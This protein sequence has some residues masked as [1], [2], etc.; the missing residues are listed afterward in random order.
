[1]KKSFS[2]LSEEPIKIACNS[3][4]MA[5]CG[6]G[7]VKC[8]IGV[9]EVVISTGNS[10]GAWGCDDRMADRILLNFA[11]FCDFWGLDWG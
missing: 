3:T 9:G 8:G 11:F 6:A 4:I 5:D 2:F 1:M 7:P 10:P